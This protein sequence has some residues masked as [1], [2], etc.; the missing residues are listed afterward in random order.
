MP[1]FKSVLNEEIFL[2]PVKRHKINDVCIAV[3]KKPMLPLIFV[4]GTAPIGALKT[5]QWLAVTTH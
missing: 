1:E 3:R 2:N 5:T 4:A